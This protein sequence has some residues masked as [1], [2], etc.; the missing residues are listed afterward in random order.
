M[1]TIHDLTGPAGKLEALL[2]EP[3]RA[4]RRP[5]WCSRT[6]CRRTAGRCIR[7]P[8]TRAPRG[9]C[10]PGARC[11]ASTSAASGRAPARSTAARARRRTSRPRSTTWPRKYP[12][13]PLWAAGFSFGSW[14]ALETGAVDDRVTTLIG[15]APPV[16]QDGLRLLEHARQH[17]AEV[18]RPWRVRRDLSRSRTCGSSTARCPSRRNWW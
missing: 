8:S 17:Q 7:R 12:D 3:E 6:R 16:T 11:C 18:L 14:I 2:D 15:I 4:R 10:G 9:W 5:P 1:P 13:L